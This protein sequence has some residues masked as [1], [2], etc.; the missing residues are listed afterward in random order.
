MGALRWVDEHA[1]R[2]LHRNGD[3]LSAYVDATAPFVVVDR[4]EIIGPVPLIYRLDDSPTPEELVALYESVGWTAYTTDPVQLHAAVA[5]SAAVVTVRD[6]GHL[7]GLAR[8]VGDGHTIAYLQDILVDP[9]YQRL[10]IG[11][12]LFRRVFA[13]FEQVRQKVLLTD[14]EHAQHA[15]YRSMGFVSADAQDPPVRTFVRFR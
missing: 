12:E 5:A 6:D 9:A 10:G 11:R 2:L 13:P 14:D 4:S 3:A 1:D 8:V 15:F 7:V